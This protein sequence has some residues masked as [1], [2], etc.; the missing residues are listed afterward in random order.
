M[1]R[2]EWVEIL[3]AIFGHTARAFDL[4]ACFFTPWASDAVGRLS[5][6]RF[7]HH[8]E[9]EV[10]TMAHKFEQSV[11]GMTFTTRPFYTVAQHRTNSCQK[12]ISGNSHRKVGHRSSG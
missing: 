3:T 4:T 5:P 11:P 7:D 10:L 9:L 12:A 8:F 6:V 1:R 2:I